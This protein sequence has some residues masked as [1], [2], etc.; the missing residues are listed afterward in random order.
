MNSD[1]LGNYICSDCCRSFNIIPDSG[2]G[3]SPYVDIKCGNCSEIKKCNLVTKN[4]LLQIIKEKRNIK[5]K[6]IGL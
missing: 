3:S 1:L 2:W 6:S 5:L 4:Q